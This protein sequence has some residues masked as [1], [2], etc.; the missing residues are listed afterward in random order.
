MKAVGAGLE[1]FV[2]WENSV[3]PSEETQGA[4]HVP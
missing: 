4:R 3:P 2:D 1:G